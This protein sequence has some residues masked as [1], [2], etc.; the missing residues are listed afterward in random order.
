M[1]E[2]FTGRMM[3]ILPHSLIGANKRVC[4]KLKQHAL[5]GSEILSS[6]PSGPAACLSKNDLRRLANNKQAP[7]KGKVLKHN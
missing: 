3:Q 7:C 1:Y 5:K 4:Q 6:G 2:Q